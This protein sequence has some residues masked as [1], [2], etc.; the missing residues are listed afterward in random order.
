MAKKWCSVSLVSLVVWSLVASPPTMLS[1]W[2]HGAA[3][4]SSASTMALAIAS[5]A[6]HT[7][8]RQILAEGRQSL[9]ECRRSLAGAMSRWDIGI[10]ELGSQGCAWANIC[11]EPIKE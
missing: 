10:R 5:A 6:K 3:L 9:A 4:P 8:S 1:T 11:S 2:W 7:T